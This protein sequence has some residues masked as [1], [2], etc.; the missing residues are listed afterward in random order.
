MRGVPAQSGAFIAMRRPVADNPFPPITLIQS[1]KRWQK[2]YFYV[3]N[4]APQ[5]DFV[6]LPAYVAGPPAGRQPQWSSRAKTL[7]PAGAAAVAR[8]RVLVQ[9]EGLTGP[10]LLTAFMAR[11]VLP[12]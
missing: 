12:L 5:G 1:M 11:W 8:L 10:D 3:K 9:A 6:N 7:S 2:F 4:V